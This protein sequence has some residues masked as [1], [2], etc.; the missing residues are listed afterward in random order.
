MAKIV[1]RPGRASF[2]ADWAILP[3]IIEHLWHERDKAKKEKDATLSQAVKIIMNSF[4]GV[5]G[6]QGCR[7]FDP[8][9]AGSITRT[10]HWLLN[11]SREF[12]EGKGFKVI[13]GD[14]DS[15][16]VCLGDG[17]SMAVNT[18]GH[19]LASSLNDF[20]RKN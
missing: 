17:D 8:R 18:A 20:L 5:L 13:Y 7:F 12:I 15:L 6:S 19:E 2:D 16:F 4:Y 1:K 3:G 11:F 10:G 14:T 9:I